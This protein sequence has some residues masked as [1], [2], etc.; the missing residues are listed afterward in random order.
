VHGSQKVK[1]AVVQIYYTQGHNIVNTFPVSLQGYGVY[2]HFQKN[3]GDMV[4]FC[5]IITIYY[6]FGF[7][8]INNSI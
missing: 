5:F 8:L 4:A 3:V 6:K 7:I 1:A 2:R